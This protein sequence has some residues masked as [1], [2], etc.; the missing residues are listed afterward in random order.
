MTGA[1]LILIV[2]SVLITALVLV[3]LYEVLIRPW[4]K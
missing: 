4:I 2:L 3:G 1:V